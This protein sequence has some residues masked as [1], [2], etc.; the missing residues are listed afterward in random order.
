MKQYRHIEAL[1]RFTLID[2]P[3]KRALTIAEMD[4][5]KERIREIEEESM[6]S[7]GVACYDSDG[8]MVP[9]R[10]S[11]P[12]GTQG[13]RMIARHLID[14][15]TTLQAWC[16]KLSRELREYDLLEK[17]G[18]FLVESTRKARPHTYTAIIG[19][20]RD[21]QSFVFLAT[22]VL[23]CDESTVRRNIQSVFHEWDSFL[24]PHVSP[25]S[26]PICAD[27]YP[28]LCKTAPRRKAQGRVVLEMAIV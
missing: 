15:Y 26:I 3:A 6:R 21:G 18:T 28:D 27:F 5:T 14:E 12:T 22:E 9:G 8:T 25:N 2:L 20:Y 11:D 19:K 16:S 17:M 1:L 13:M 4:N 7:V 10:I 24:S 23:Y